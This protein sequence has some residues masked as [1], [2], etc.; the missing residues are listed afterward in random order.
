MDKWDHKAH[1][2]VYEKIPKN[3]LIT[4]VCRENIVNAIA[5]AL[6]QEANEAAWDG[7]EYGYTLSEELEHSLEA[8]ESI[9]SK[10]RAKYGSQYEGRNSM[11]R[12]DYL[13]PCPEQHDF[14]TDQLLA[15]DAS[16]TDYRAELKKLIFANA[17]LLAENS[18]LKK[19][20]EKFKAKRKEKK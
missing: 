13:L 5:A 15:L 12:D 20:I 3:E 14:R 6:R 9:I 11:S 19:E 4:G 17:K 10:M 1:C 2:I 8:G 18:A 7:Y 16:I